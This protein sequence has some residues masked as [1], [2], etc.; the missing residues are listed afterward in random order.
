M[1]SYADKTQSLH[2]E[3]SPWLCLGMVFSSATLILDR[4]RASRPEH[5]IEPYS[6]FGTSLL[7]AHLKRFTVNSNTIN[8]KI[9]SNDAFINDPPSVDCIISNP[10]M[11]VG[12]SLGYPSQQS[13]KMGG[14]TIQD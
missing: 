4:V 1:Q 7:V 12:A 2:N 11:I 6:H 3:S 5:V 8:W 10:L 14:N 9:T 13:N